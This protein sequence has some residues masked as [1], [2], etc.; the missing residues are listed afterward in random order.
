MTKATDGK[1]PQI[2]YGNITDLVVNQ[3]RD[4]ILANE[5]QPG[6]WIRQADIAGQL[7]VSIMPVR[8][9]LRQLQTEGL[10]VSF[11]RRGFKVAELSLEAFLELDRISEE[12]EKL[13]C[14]WLAEDFSR[15]PLKKMRQTLAELEEAE[16]ARDIPGRLEMVRKFRFIIYD[17]AEKPIL[18][19]LHVN[20]LNMGTPYRRLFASVDELTPRRIGVY[21]KIYQACM[22]QNLDTLLEAMSELYEMARQAVISQLSEIE[23]SS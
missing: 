14:T 9:A 18:H 2:T 13:S 12:L 4:M 16:L 8:E 22:D 11:P 17:A 1:A 23:E 5:L 10:A 20:L 6:Q 7:G 3:I 19:G 21:Q 15:V